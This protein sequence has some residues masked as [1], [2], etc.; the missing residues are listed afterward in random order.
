V[1]LAPT[2]GTCAS[3]LTDMHAAPAIAN[4]VGPNFGAV[5]GFGDLHAIGPLLTYGLI[6]AVLA[7]VVSAAIWRSHPAP[8][9][10]TRPR[11]QAR[12]L[13]GHLRC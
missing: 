8:A 9:A 5:G 2:M 1:V 11:R 4:H 13:R 12:M 7:L 10:G 6:V 3:T